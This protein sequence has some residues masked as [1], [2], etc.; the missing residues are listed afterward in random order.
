MVSADARIVWNAR[1]ASC[2]NEK[3][4]GA[5]ILAAFNATVDN[6]KFLRP[7]D[8]AKIGALPLTFS[9]ASLPDKVLSPADFACALA[10]CAASGKAVHLPGSPSAFAWFK[11]FFGA[12]DTRI[13]GG[14]AGN[15]ANALAALDADSSV[16]PAL[17]SPRQAELFGNRVR[18]PV[19]S[20]SGKL[21]LI[22]ARRAGR[23]GDETLESWIFELAE[24]AEL[25]VNG[26]KIRVP[27]A[28]RLIVSSDSPRFRPVFPRAFEPLLPQLGRRFHAAFLSGYFYVRDAETL[29]QAA[30][31][32]RVLRENGVRT[33]W[34]YV[35]AQ[36]PRF[37][38]RILLEVGGSVD[39]VGFNEVELGR[40][41]RALGFERE[42]KAIVERDNAAAVFVGVRR[43]MKTLRVRQVQVHSLGYSIVVLNKGKCG[44]GGESAGRADAVAARDACVF[45][46]LVTA[47]K[48]AKGAAPVSRG[49][50][51]RVP[52]LN[53]GNSELEQLRVFASNFSFGKSE[54]RGFLQDGV[55]EFKDCFAVVVPAPVTPKPKLT[56]GLGDVFSSVFLAKE[57][58]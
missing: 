19:I 29:A 35:P 51:L 41:L 36:S 1:F 30:A 27:R 24:G 5:R 4:S 37:E 22:P 32:A 28:N 54:A 43:L 44:N 38:K 9:R 21:S 18:V 57:K 6:V 23:R 3:I 46:S 53:V 17:L 34:E 55:A 45:A 15:A 8:F 40:A 48:A 39:S 13:L 12:P 16:Y 58:S 47:L 49:D 56:V 33:H 31:Q 26:K 20:G 10:A 7:R 52:A 25:R 50:V 14:Q 11:K 2:R 42:A